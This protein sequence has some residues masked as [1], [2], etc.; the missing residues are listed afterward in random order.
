MLP[1]SYSIVNWL[2]VL[3]YVRMDIRIRL[4]SYLEEHGI[5]A[6]RLAQETKTE[7]APGTIYSLARGDS[8]RL[9]LQSLATVIGALERMTGETVNFDD[10]L[11]KVQ[12]R[13]EGI[14]AAGV[15]YTGDPETDAVL[16]DHPDIMERIRKLEAGESKLIP[17]ED[18]AAQLGIEL[19]R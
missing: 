12:P 10:L 5:S 1:R 4:G 15:P 7:A 14:S 8:K 9:D 2:I 3:Y 17:L 19:R 16:D 11:E 6:Y 18:V 13:P